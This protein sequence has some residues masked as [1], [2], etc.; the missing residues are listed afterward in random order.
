MP[1]QL[2][3]ILFFA[4]HPL[5][6]LLWWLSAVQMGHVTGVDGVWGMDTGCFAYAGITT[7]NVR[8]IGNR[9]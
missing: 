4:Q 3:M 1:L 8:M 5:T 7:Q 6:G 2:G 9:Q